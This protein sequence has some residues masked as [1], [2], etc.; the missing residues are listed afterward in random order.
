[1]LAE[2]AVRGGEAIVQAPQI[3]DAKAPVKMIGLHR[4]WLPLDVDYFL[5][6]L[7]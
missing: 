2:D 3:G 4:V 6:G 7:D 5:I 1:L